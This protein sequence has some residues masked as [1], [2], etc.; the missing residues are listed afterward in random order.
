MSVDFS[1][2]TLTQYLDQ[3]AS[4]EPVPGGGSAG[5]V[6][7]ALGAALISMVTR[8]SIG[9]KTNTKALDKQLT[10][11]L[12]KSEALRQRFLQLA[13]EDSKAYLEVVA[14]RTQD[15]KAKRRAATRAAAVPK[16][17]CRLCYKAVELTPFLV[18]KGNPYLLSDV[19]VAI[20]LL[21]A[22][23]NASAVMIK[24]NA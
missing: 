5:A 1:R 23:F 16:E 10:K 7:A 4:R 13:A 14:A 15:S 3:L 18:A 6:S 24:A 21:M 20:E 8:Y 12:E 2:K 9:R 22:G 11:L 17:I 19:E